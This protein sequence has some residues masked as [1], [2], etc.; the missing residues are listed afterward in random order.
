MNRITAI[1]SEISEFHCSATRYVIAIR[2]TRHRTGASVRTD[3]PPITPNV[4]SASDERIR[5]IGKTGC[6]TPV[7]SKTSTRLRRALLGRRD[8][9]HV[10]HRPYPRPQVLE[11]ED[12]ADDT[13]E[14]R[15]ED[16]DRQRL[17]A[18]FHEHWW[19]R[20]RD[21]GQEDAV[22]RGDAVPRLL[23]LQECLERVCR[24]NRQE[25]GIG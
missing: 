13:Q 20:L 21:H 5:A 8:P 4:S 22:L 1:T 25:H 14:H 2:T 23:L 24:P 10:V 17:R 12:E 19:I 16:D 6:R 9:L 18:P 3:I 15:H 11:H 7:P